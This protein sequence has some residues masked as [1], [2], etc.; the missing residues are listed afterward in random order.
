MLL[1]GRPRHDHI[2]S[3][4]VRIERIINVMHIEPGIILVVPLCVFTWANFIF[5]NQCP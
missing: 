2:A 5:V 3:K 4:L 1:L